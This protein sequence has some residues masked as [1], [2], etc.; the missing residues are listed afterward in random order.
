MRIN[1]VTRPEYEFQLKVLDRTDSKH[2]V[3][4]DV[5]ANIG[6]YSSQL[7]HFSMLTEKSFTSYL[8]EPQYH[9]LSYEHP[10]SILAR[11]GKIKDDKAVPQEVKD[12]LPFKVYDLAVSDKVD[13]KTLIVPTSHQTGNDFNTREWASFN[14]REVFKEGEISQQIVKTTTIKDFMDEQGIKTIDILKID[15][16]GHEYECL[17]GC[18]EYLY[19]AFIQNIQLEYGNSYRTDDIGLTEIRNMLEGRGYSLYVL[20]EFPH[21]IVPLPIEHAIEHY[22]SVLNKGKDIIATTDKFLC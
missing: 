6:F 5:G 16:E 20:M 19:P 13:H 3:V 10:H 18:G 15:T 1:P 9:H 8:F 21:G 14:Y 2:V 22:M 12:N 4:F 17:R 7:I 11:Y